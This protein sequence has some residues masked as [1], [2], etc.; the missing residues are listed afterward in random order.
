MGC[1]TYNKYKKK[2][3]EIYSVSLDKEKGSWQKGIKDDKI[4]WLQVSELRYWS[5]SVVSQY[6]IEEIP[7]SILLDRQGKIVIKGKTGNELENK[8]KEALNKI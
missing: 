5:S 3:L 1:Q 6:N 8:I 7:Y 4:S 2:G